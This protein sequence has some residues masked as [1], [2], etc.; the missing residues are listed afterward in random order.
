MIPLDV[1]RNTFLFQYIFIKGTEKRWYSYDNS[2]IFKVLLY[3]LIYIIL[4]PFIAIYE[5][6]IAMVNAMTR[7]FGECF[8]PR[9]RI[10]V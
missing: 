9:V 5:I 8:A 2:N 1:K 7:D 3:N 4:C 6:V 10:I